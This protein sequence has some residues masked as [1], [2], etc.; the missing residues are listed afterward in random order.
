[1]LPQQ[2]HFR[3]ILQGKTA[4][5]KSDSSLVSVSK[6]I[7]SPARV[8]QLFHQKANLQLSSPDTQQRIHGQSHK[9]GRRVQGPVYLSSLSEEN[10]AEGGSF[11]TCV[12]I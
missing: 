3:E 6:S 4:K 1:M 7:S 11:T 2:L 10:E 5:K 8:L 9:S 12:I